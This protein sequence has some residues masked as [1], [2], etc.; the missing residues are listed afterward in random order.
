MSNFSKFAKSVAD[1]FQS[2]V[3][4]DGVFVAGVTGDELHAAYLAAFPPGTDPI[5]V[6][7]TEHDCSCCKGFI[8]RVGNV[9]TIKDGKV[10]T[11]WDDAAD[12]APA[13]YDTVA[14]AMRAKVLN[15]PISG[16]FRVSKKETSFGAKTS[17]S[18]DKNTKKVLTWE[19]FYTGQIP[20]NLLVES[21]GQVCGDYAT[22][23]Q[24][25]ERGL[26]ELSSEAVSEVLDLINSNSLYRGEEHKSAITTFQK[27]QKTYFK[28]NASE[29]RHNYVWEH[30]GD[31]ASRFRNT[32][33]GTLVQDLSEG[34][35]LDH[36]VR[37][38]ETKVAPQN[39]KRPTA[40][41][42]PAMAQ[43]ALETIKELDLEP[44][45]SR[46]YATIKDVS[47]QDVIWVD[48]DAK[49]LMKGGIGD[50]LMAHVKKAA[51]PPPANNVV[52]ISL[53]DFLSTVV[54]ETTGM[55]VLLSNEH[56]G[57]LMALT[58][59]IHPE[60]KKLFKWDNDFA[61]SYG[62]NV[63]DSIKE[64]VKKAGGRIEGTLR[65]SLSW[66]NYDDLDIHV[67]EPAGKGRNA[68]IDH[69][70]FGCRKGWTGGEL[71]VDMNAGSGTTR[72]PVENVVW[73]NK[74]PD[75]AYRVVVNNY[76]LR[77]TANPG[78][79]VEV[80]CG[81]KLH[82]FT[83]NKAVR[84]GGN[85]NVC[86]LHMKDGLIESIDGSDA[87]IT[88]AAIKQEKWGLTTGQYVK[89]ATVTKSP[90][91]WGDNKV[92]NK[93]T[94]FVLEGCKADEAL[95]GFYNEFLHPRLESHRKVFEIIGDKT[96]CEPTDDHLAGLGFSSTKKD[97]VTIRVKTGRGQR[98]YNVNV[99]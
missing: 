5:F 59:P 52:E 15:A 44:A 56:L 71:D 23:V 26:K 88:S 8:R 39:Y 66:G 51:P 86:T 72:E 58:A 30:A 28:L 19:H 63:A 78:F 54:P 35:D 12:H 33:I 11:I 17:Q 6:K 27:A 80:E 90:N 73:T 68:M 79:V 98:I 62:G 14:I 65:I 13:P 76:R 48:G 96:K 46:R 36:A 41:V 25:F 37:K 4:N 40:L 29:A 45:L 75:G 21:P 99:G 67:H 92:G 7:Q 85:I 77:E 53:E 89:V 82:H 50:L 83:Y 97:K 57:N 93:H 55:E 64:R 10:H 84:D 9:V 91:Y 87:S 22:T 16:L 38:F 3:K 49:P 42:T 20:N 24:V 69:I 32:V 61:W 60:P 43:K 70:Y 18:Q 47:V 81:N 1:R 74:V 31:P 95:R 34:T 2:V 94:F